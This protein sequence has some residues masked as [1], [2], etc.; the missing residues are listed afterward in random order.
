MRATDEAERPMALR[1]VGD[2]RP[3]FQPYD[4]TEEAARLEGGEK[5]EISTSGGSSS[6]SS[7]LSSLYLYC[8]SIVV[9]FRGQSLWMI[10]VRVLLVVV[11]AGESTQ[12]FAVVDC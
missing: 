12:A 9:L 8:F 3:L 7:S 2:E 1:V 5:A 6:S 10:L 4:K 11:T